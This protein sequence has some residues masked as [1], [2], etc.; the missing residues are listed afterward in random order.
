MQI[1]LLAKAQKGKQQQVEKTFLFVCQF[2]GS[3]SR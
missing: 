3:F 2:D 1:I